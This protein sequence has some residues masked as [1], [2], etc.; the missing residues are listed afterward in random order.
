MWSLKKQDTPIDQHRH[1]I[2]C[3]ASRSTELL[4]D[5]FEGQGIGIADQPHDPEALEQT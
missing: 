3:T 2:N 1:S 5:K 4:S